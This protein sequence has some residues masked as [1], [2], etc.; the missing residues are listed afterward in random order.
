MPCGECGA[1]TAKRDRLWREYSEA[2]ETLNASRAS[3]DVKRYVQLRAAV[4]KARTEFNL[5]ETEF[6]EHQN[7][8]AMGAGS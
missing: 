6:R 1:L 3:T 7:R 4:D 2:A 8:H 5:A